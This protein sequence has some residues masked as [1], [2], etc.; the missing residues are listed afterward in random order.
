M[1]EYRPDRTW[2]PICTK[3]FPGDRLWVREAWTHESADAEGGFY[4]PDYKA[5]ANGQPTDGRWRSPIHM[6]RWA[7]RLTLVVTDVR[8]QRLQEISGEDAQ[9]EGIYPFQH[10][11][12]DIGKLWGHHVVGIVNPPDRTA[13]TSK[14]AGWDNPR[15]AFLALWNSLHGPEAWDADPWVAALTITVHR[16]NI[17][18]MQRGAE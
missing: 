1:L 5:T 18:H 7:S 16:C 4:R 14:P 15:H 11:D 10:D 2:R 17:D 3:F 9:A 12:P 13:V 6:P 8:V